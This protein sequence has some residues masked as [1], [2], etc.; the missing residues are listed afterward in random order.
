MMYTLS[1]P[2]T[3]IMEGAEYGSFTNL[4]TA[5]QGRAMADGSLTQQWSAHWERN[6]TEYNVLTG[7][8][9]RKLATGFTKTYTTQDMALVKARIGSSVPGADGALAAHGLMDNGGGVQAL[10]T[11][12]PAPET[13]NVYLSTG[14]GP[15]GTSSRVSWARRTRRD[16]G[17]STRCTSSATG[18]SRRGRRTPRPSTSA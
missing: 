14:T 1:T 6:G 3:F 16:T 12:R 18:S 5:Y 15:P 11:V 8:P 17:A 10:Y 2:E 7:G 9:V 13:R 4:R